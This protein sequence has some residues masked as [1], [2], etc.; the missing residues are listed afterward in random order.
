MLH[1]LHVFMRFSLPHPDNDLFGPPAD[2]PK[3][4]ALHQR[5]ETSWNRADP[6][7]LVEGGPTSV[8]EMTTSNIIHIQLFQISTTRLSLLFSS[9]IQTEKIREQWNLSSKKTIPFFFR[10]NQSRNNHNWYSS[11]I[12]LYIEYCLHCNIF[13][14]SIL[15]SIW[16]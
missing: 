11:F 10:L 8:N 5:R 7:P 4:S 2:Y 16:G 1:F 13:F 14:D 6:P 9:E 3:L 12:Y 15:V